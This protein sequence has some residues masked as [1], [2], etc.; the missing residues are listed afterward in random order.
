MHCNI[1]KSRVL[2]FHYKVNK[3]DN[4]NKDAMVKINGTILTSDNNEELTKNQVLCV[5]EY[6]ISGENTLF[7]LDMI[8]ETLIELETEEDY[9]NIENTDK[10]LEKCQKIGILEA[11]KLLEQHFGV[12]LVRRRVE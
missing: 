7:S 9:L 11:E 5:I 8:S 4:E 1:L 6:K 10:L 12:F 3:I 2:E